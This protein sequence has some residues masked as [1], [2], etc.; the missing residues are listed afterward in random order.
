[1]K[2]S[3]RRQKLARNKNLKLDPETTQPMVKIYNMYLPG[4]LICLLHNKNGT[5][6]ALGVNASTT[7]T[8]FWSKI[9]W[10]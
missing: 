1:M 5:P 8:R 9:T 3:F 10:N 7:G 4:I 6:A 2:L